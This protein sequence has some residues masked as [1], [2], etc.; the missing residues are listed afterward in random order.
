[1]SAWRQ[2]CL[3]Q[4]GVG[5]VTRIQCYSLLTGFLQC[6]G[7]PL[8]M[9]NYLAQKSTGPRLRNL[10]LDFAH[11]SLLNCLL[12]SEQNQDSINKKSIVLQEERIH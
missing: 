1:M 9:K 12:I 7:Q 11:L 10:S 5:G 3:P 8:T 4:L 2:F 6:T